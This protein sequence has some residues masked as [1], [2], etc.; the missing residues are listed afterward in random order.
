M[1]RVFALLIL[2]MAAGQAVA[3]DWKV[4]P[5]QSVIR[6]SGT[7]AGKPFEGVFEKWTAEISFSSENLPAARVR[8]EIDTASATTGNGLYDGTLKG[9]DWFNVGVFPVAVF[10]AQQFSHLGGDTYRA[11][12][13]L[14][15]RGKA[16]P[17]VFD[18][19]LHIDGS[20]ARMQASSELDRI[21]F[22]LGVKSDSK[23]A[24]VSKMIGLT[25]KVGAAGG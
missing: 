13:T 4:D 21:A 8:V 15:I 5:A 16:L 20:T 11:E 9:E 10:E 19:T 2:L 3:S 1:V 18:F 17:F 14:T 12:G 22:G 7:H 25:L 6:F 24:W 23:A